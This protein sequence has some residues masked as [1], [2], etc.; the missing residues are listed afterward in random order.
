MQFTRIALGI[1]AV[2]VV[3]AVSN[4]RSLLNLCDKCT[5]TDAVNTSC[6]KEEHVTRMYFILLQHI[7]YGIVE[8]TLFVLFRGDLF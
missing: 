3:N 5:C 8:N 4:V 7:G 1:L 6:R 2:E